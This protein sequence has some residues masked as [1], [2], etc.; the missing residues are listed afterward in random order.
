MKSPSIVE[1][2]NVKLRKNAKS[3]KLPFTR[4]THDKMKW[5]KNSTKDGKINRFVLFYNVFT[6]KLFS[7]AEW[8]SLIKL[9]QFLIFVWKKKNHEASRLYTLLCDIEFHKVKFFS[10]DQTDKD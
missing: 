9:E 1:K 10:I 4:V 3:E 7:F 6:K 8:M 2:F 5:I